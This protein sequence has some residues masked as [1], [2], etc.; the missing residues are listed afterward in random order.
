MAVTLVGHGS[1]AHLAARHLRSFQMRDIRHLS[2]IALRKNIFAGAV[3]F[4]SFPSVEVFDWT[5]ST[6]SIHWKTNIY[7]A[8]TRVR[9]SPVPL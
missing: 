5:R 2:K 4:H 9:R 6:S 8:E 7:L 3:L 1:D